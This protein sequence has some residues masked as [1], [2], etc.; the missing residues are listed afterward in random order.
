MYKGELSGTTARLKPVCEV[1]GSGRE[2]LKMASPFPCCPAD[3][4]CLKRKTQ[5]EKNETEIF[6]EYLEC[7]IIANII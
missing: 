2:E 4:G 1:G 3:G 5:I 6:Y 7:E